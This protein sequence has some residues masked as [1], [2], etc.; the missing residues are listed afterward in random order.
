MFSRPVLTTNPSAFNVTTAKMTSPTPPHRSITCSPTTSPKAASPAHNEGEGK[1]SSTKP[2]QTDALTHPS[3]AKPLSPPPSPL[4]EHD[5]SEF[6]AIDAAAQPPIAKRRKVTCEFKDR[7]VTRRQTLLMD[8]SEPSTNVRAGQKRKLTD[9]IDLNEGLATEL[10]QT[11]AQNFINTSNLKAGQMFHKIE[12]TGIQLPEKNPLWG[13]IPYSETFGHYED[14]Y[15]HSARSTNAWVPFDMWEDRKTRF[16]VGQFQTVDGKIINQEDNLVLKLIDMRPDANGAPRR[17][18]ITWSWGRPKNWN[19]SRTIKILNDRR[20][21]AIERITCEVPW[22]VQE[23]EY[24][25]ELF[26]WKPEI[27]IMELAERFNYRFKGEFTT[28]DV[29]LDIDEL[30]PGR[31]LESIRAE[32]LT[33]KADY[34]QLKVPK[35]RAIVIKKKIDGKVRLSALREQRMKAFEQPASAPKPKKAAK[36]SE[37]LVQHAQPTEPSSPLTS[38]PSTPCAVVQSESAT[39]PFPDF[40]I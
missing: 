11:A 24:M 6:V 19:D 34:D 22:T 12:S 8:S 26:A 25:V 39:E 13:D 15:E 14:F 23:R 31:T 20:R 3:S 37:A 1:F 30:H 2:T 27:S 17:E 9:S 29:T 38:V 33:F 40:D 7:R 32:Y 16:A 4:S 21:D 28:T 18:P 35:T 10:A 5:D 36:K